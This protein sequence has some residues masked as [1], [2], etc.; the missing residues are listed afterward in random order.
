MTVKPKN[1]LN[2][3]IQ[4]GPVSYELALFTPVVLRETASNAIADNP[5]G[6]AKYWRE[7]IE[8][9]PNF[10]SMKENMVVFFLN[11]RRRI[12]GHHIAC[13][14]TIDQVICMPREIFRLAIVT[15]AQA[16]IIA[17]NHP[18]GDATPSDSDIH[19]TKKIIRAGQILSIELLDSI[20]LG[21]TAN[22]SRGYTSLREMGY[23]C[24]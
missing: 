4:K 7:Q 20:I 23:F 21:T 2:G 11:T 15:G 8:T 14:G 5:E 1:T 18:S 17:H 19:V 3:T 9:A 6:V 24:Y 10:D 16:V 13:V 12:I 22:G